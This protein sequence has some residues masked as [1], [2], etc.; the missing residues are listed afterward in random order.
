MNNKVQAWHLIQSFCSMI[1][2]R[3]DTKVQHHRFNNGVKFYM[4]DFYGSK[5][6]LRKKTCIETG[7]H[8]KMEWLKGN[9]S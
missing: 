8:T 2:T 3:F 1:E 9:I 6:V 7:T 5:G 4:P